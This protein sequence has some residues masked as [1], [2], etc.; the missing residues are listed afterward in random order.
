M[1]NILIATYLTPIFT[2]SLYTKNIRYFCITT[3]IMSILLEIAVKL[4]S[5]NIGLKKKSRASCSSLFVMG[6]MAILIS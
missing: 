2:A 1:M 6:I 5:D 4:I 3:G